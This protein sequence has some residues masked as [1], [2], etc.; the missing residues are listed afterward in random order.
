MDKFLIRVLIFYFQIDQ[1]LKETWLI[2][3][4]RTQEFTNGFYNLSVT[5]RIELFQNYRV[6]LRGVCADQR[7]K[8]AWR[9]LANFF[10]YGK[11]QTIKNA[12]RLVNNDFV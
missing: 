6:N 9:E 4:Q 2:L 8:Q 1:C 10:K 3:N 11:K 12:I 5:V 7:A